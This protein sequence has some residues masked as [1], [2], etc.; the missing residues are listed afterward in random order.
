MIDPQQ[1]LQEEEDRED[2]LCGM[3]FFHGMF[4]HVGDPIYDVIMKIMGCY[5][6]N[7]QVSWDVIMIWDPM[8]MKI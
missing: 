4:L 2:H 8:Y 1:H 7:P 6:G 3:D 5:H